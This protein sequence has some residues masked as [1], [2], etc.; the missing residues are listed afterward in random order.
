MADREADAEKLNLGLLADAVAYLRRDRVEH[1]GIE[2]HVPLL[3]ALPVRFALHRDLLPLVAEEANDDASAITE[4]RNAVAEETLLPRR[5][6]KAGVGIAD[7]KGESFG[8]I[9]GDGLERR[10]LRKSIPHFE[11]VP[12]SCIGG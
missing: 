3:A 4:V 6:E 2:A 5:H 11:Y 10:G 8:Q 1:L 9:V 12:R 7:V